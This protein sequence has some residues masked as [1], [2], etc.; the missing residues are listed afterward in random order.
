[1]SCSGRRG[2][3]FGVALAVY[4]CC[5]MAAATDVPPVSD[6]PQ[7]NARSIQGGPFTLTSHV[8]AT[9]T[10]KSFAG[11]F[12]LVY[13]GYTYCPEVCPTDLAVMGQAITLLGEAGDRVQPLFITFDPVR[14]TQE[15]LAQYIEAFHPRLIGL[16]GTKEQTFAAADHYGVDVS[17]TYKADTPGS[18]YS[19]NHSAFTYLVGPQGRLRVMFRDGTSAELMARTIRKKL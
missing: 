9:I 11:D 4:S 18:A 2:F 19:M 13:F 17:A 5:L 8:G 3:F 14:D 7:S 6:F 10:E 1:M 15:R 12:L 16:T